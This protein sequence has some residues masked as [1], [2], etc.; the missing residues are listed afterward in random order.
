MNNMLE[1]C[2]RGMSTSRW[3]EDNWH[4]RA[5]AQVETL[6]VKTPAFQAHEVCLSMY[7]VVY[8]FSELIN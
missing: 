6:I 4:V 8:I 2:L 1:K 7:V 5:S 3:K